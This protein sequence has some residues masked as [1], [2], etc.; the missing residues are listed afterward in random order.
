MPPVTINDPIIN[1]PFIHLR[2][3]YGG[4]V[5]PKRHFRFDD[6]GITEQIVEGR[7][8]G[9]LFYNGVN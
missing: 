9:F 5:A 8:G 7:R 6:N 1:S 3:S 2:L 4:Q